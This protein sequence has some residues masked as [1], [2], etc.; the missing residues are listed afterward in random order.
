MGS[1]GIDED[2]AQVVDV[3]AGGAC[4]EGVAQDGEKGAAVVGGEHGGGVQLQRPGTGEG[5]GIDERSG[6][7]SEQHTSELQSLMRISYDV[8]CL[9][10]KKQTQ[11]QNLYTNTM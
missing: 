3:G 11:K 2:D 8:F 10:K 9:K 7:R 6:G 1:L 5:G 4:D